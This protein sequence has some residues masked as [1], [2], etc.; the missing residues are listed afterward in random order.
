MLVRL[1][2]L[3]EHLDE[4][5]EAAQK[6]DPMLPYT[7]PTDPEKNTAHITVMA[8]LKHLK[9]SIRPFGKTCPSCDA[10][11]PETSTCLDMVTDSLEQKEKHNAHPKV[12][13]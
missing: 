12:D 10:E 11:A 3:T 8:M 2:I 5:L 1:N 7:R 13:S 9:K 4:A 6:L